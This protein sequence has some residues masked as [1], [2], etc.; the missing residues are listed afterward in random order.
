MH[1]PPSLP[2]LLLS[3]R[4]FLQNE[5][6]PQEV[7]PRFKFRTL[8]AANVLA[9]AARE[10]ER[11]QP[12][13]EGEAARL[14]SLASRFGASTDATLSELSAWLAGEIRAGNLDCAPG[15]EIWRHLKETVME[16]LEVSN[17]SFLRR[18]SS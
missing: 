15:S 4:H 3:V 14:Q 13:C 9:I 8:V 18:V 17:P 5:V 1:D 6:L 16:S 11:S 7:E 2:E 12:I 10:A